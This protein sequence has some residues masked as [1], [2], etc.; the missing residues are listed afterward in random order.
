AKDAEALAQ[1]KGCMAC[2][3]KNE[4]KVGPSYAAVAQKYAGRADAVDYLAGKIKNG[5]VGV[6]GQ[7]P[8]PAQNVTDQEARDL[9][10]WV[11]STK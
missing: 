8:M 6:W 5:G 2:H 9:A 3:A 10:K 1:Q 7:V 11:L 4:K